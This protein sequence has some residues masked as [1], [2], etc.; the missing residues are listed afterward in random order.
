MKFIR[1]VFYSNG[2]FQMIYFWTNLFLVLITVAFIMKLLSKP[3]ISD[4]LLLGLMGLVGGLLAI[5][6]FDRNSQRRNIVDQNRHIPDG[7]K[8]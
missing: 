6:N 4:G 7:A 2:K 8:S 5:F 3:A 1:I